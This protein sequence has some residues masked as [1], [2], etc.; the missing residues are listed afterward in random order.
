MTPEVYVLK[1]RNLKKGAGMSQSEYACE[2]CDLMRKW[3]KGKRAED[4]DQLFDHF[5]LFLSIY[6]E[7]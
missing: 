4:Y 7:M 3:I 5:A 2:M 1:F 6:T